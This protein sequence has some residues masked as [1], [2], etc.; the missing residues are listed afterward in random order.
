MAETVLGI[1]E[2]LDRILEVAVVLLPGGMLTRGRW[3][4]E[5]SCFVPLVS[6]SSGRLLSCLGSRDRTPPSFR[7]LSIT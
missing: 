4:S 6:W 7:R 5:A 3:P 1:S 2:Q